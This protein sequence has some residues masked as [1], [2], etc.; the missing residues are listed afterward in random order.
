MQGPAPGTRT[1]TPKWSNIQ[2]LLLT[3]WFLGFRV[4]GFGLRV[5]GLGCRVLGFG[6]R[7]QGLILLRTGSCESGLVW[8][9]T[10]PPASRFVRITP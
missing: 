2:G 1:W 8:I 7:V 6:F 3:H 5:S 4:Q 9:S 10:K